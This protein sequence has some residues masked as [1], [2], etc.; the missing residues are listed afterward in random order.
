MATDLQN[1]ESRKWSQV[2]K[3]PNPKTL[4][5]T[6]NVHLLLALVTEAIV[7]SSKFL[8]QISFNSDLRSA[9]A[10]L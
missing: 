2:H 5:P 1:D 10:V 4:D 6:F 7:G 3:P 9:F 8:S